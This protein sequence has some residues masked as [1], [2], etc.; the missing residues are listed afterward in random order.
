MPY[1]GTPPASLLRPARKPRVGTELLCEFVFRPVAQL[2]VLAL[3]PLRIPP[4][5]VVVA[6]TGTGLTAALAL[7]RG[8]LVL[9]ALLLQAKTV[10]DNADG[11]LA[12][13]TGRISVLGR[14]LDSESDLL[15]NAALCAALGWTTGRWVLAAGAFLALTVVLGVN[16]NLER[17]Y[18]LERGEA[19]D[20]MPVA[21]GGVHLLER[22]YGLLY[23]WQDRLVERFCEWRLRGRDGAARLVYHDRLG[24]ETLANLGL[25]TQLAVFGLCLAA[26]RPQAFAWFA[27]ACAGLLVPLALWRGLRLRRAHT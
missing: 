11:Q 18:R 9:A 7:A 10:L 5:A 16:F 14:Y 19:S 26:G 6:A 17:L 12:R 27:V 4:P 23:A 3:A 22:V 24:V 2:L 15:V 20:P 1:T 25:S 13:A 21:R 8:E